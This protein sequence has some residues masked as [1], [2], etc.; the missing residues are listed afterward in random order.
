[1]PEPTSPAGGTTSRSS[2]KLTA[3]TSISFSPTAKISISV[4]GD[5][6]EVEPRVP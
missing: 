6:P 5:E 3:N 2:A 1:M 4:P